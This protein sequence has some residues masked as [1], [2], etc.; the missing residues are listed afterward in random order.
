VRSYLIHR[1]GPLGA[2]PH[3]LTG[4]LEEEKEVSIRRAL[5]LALGE[6]D[7][8]RIPAHERERLL[9]RMLRLYREEPDAGLHAAAEWLLRRWNQEDKITDFVQ[10]WVHDRAKRQARLEQIRKE[11]DRPVASAPG[12]KWYVNGQG[13]TMVVVPGPATFRM[14]SPVTEERREGGPKGKIEAPHQKRTRGTFAIAAHE[15]TVG[16][17]RKYRKNHVFNEVVCPS[18]DHP[19]NEVSWYDAAAYCNWLSEQ[20]GIAP[21]QWCYEPNQKKLYEEGMK[22]KANYLSLEGYRLP[23]EA[24]WEYACRAGAMT[25][26]YYGET[27]ELLGRYACY[28]MVSQARGMFRAGSLKPN[29]LGAF[30]LLGNILEWCQE[31]MLDYT[32]GPHPSEDKEDILVVNRVQGV[33]EDRVLRGG[34]Y[35]LLA[36][37]VRAAGRFRY[38]PAD[39]VDNGGFRPARTFR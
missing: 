35:G 25:S 34:S 4:R 11:L 15:V 3:A 9:P 36:W 5:V 24:E 38:Y 22:L 6:F 37:S 12:G 29:D 27:E 1:L 28:M 20:E 10:E 13:Q 26:R 30:D 21:E 31:R 17:F 32:P 16:Q 33:Q 23:S 14:G 2:D 7:A 8:D 19:V 18:E 39:T